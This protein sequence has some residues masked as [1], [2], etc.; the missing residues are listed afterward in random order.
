MKND[1]KT[2]SIYIDHAGIKLHAVDWGGNGPPIVLIHGS[3][4]TSRSWNAV[5]RRI[6]DNFRVIA[7]DMRSHGKSDSPVTGYTTKQRKID[8][9]A[10]IKS[11]GIGDHYLMAHSLGGASTALYAAANPDKVLGM[12]LIEPVMEGPLH[13][14][15]VGILDENM[16]EV[17][18][19]GRRNSW[20][21]L[22]DLKNR[23]RTNEM[24]KVWTEEV[25]ADVLN[26]E[27][28]VHE[29]GRA[30]AMWHMNSYNISEMQSDEFSLL[31]LASKMSM[32]IS[33]MVAGNN[34][35][36]STHIQP[37]SEKLPDAKLHVYKNLGHAIYMEDPEL[38]AD[39]TKQMFLGIDSGS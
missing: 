37:F 10:M 38:V 2:K 39:H 22:E 6:R 16:E 28:I 8:T 5:A 32:P 4:R 14:S 20:S 12:I 9:E 3:R 26:E 24:T 13:Y 33:I 7:L 17:Q 18:G 27:T 31:K 35:M 30:E 34:K 29:D 21:T 19:R 36:L 25:L 11:I 15:R 1:D 23:L